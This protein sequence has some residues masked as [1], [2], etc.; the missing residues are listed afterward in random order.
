MTTLKAACVGNVQGN[1]VFDVIAYDNV[2]GQF[3]ADTS[4]RATFEK[5]L[6]KTAELNKSLKQI[7]PTKIMSL[8][9]QLSQTNSCN[10]PELILT[11]Q[12][13]RWLPTNYEIKKGEKGFPPNLWDD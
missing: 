12:T 7:Q 2:I 6:W 9:W 10:L 11:H 4:T 13:P 3:K 1:N 5:T 8:C